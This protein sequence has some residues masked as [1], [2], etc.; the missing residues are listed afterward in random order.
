MYL[1]I[2]LVQQHVTHTRLTHTRYAPTHMYL[3]IALV[4]EDVQDAEHALP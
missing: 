3:G 1:G 4:Q 2:S